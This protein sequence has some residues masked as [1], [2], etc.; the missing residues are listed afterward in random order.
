MIIIKKLTSSY[1]PEFWTLSQ[2]QRARLTKSKSEISEKNRRKKTRKDKI[3]NQV[4]KDKLERNT[5]EIT[6]E[7]RTTLIARTH[8]EKR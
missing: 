5:T 6:I 4:L 1:A 8:K 3:R 2:R 7:K